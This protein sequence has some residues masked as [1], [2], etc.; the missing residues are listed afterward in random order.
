MSELGE[1]EL[2]SR[3]F[4]S[5]SH[6]ENSTPIKDPRSDG[7]L[8]DIGDDAAVLNVP[9]GQRLVVSSDTLVEGVHFPKRSPASLIAQRALRVNLSDMAAMGATPRWFTL[10]LTL[11]EVSES[12]V[13]DFSESLH[14]DARLFE[15]RLVGG[16]TTRGPLNIGIQMMGTVTDETRAITRM[17][18][19]EGD[20][21]LVTG[22]LGDAA[23][24]LD[25]LDSDDQN[26]STA[27]LLRRYWIP[28]PRVEFAQSAQKYIH[29]AC[30]ISDGLLADVGHICEASELG[31]EVDA[32]K[33]PISPALSQCFGSAATEKALTG[34]DDY[35]LCMAVSA[36]HVEQVQVLGDRYGCPVT[37]MGEFTAA[38]GIRCVNADDEILSSDALNRKGYQHF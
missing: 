14:E 17:G 25:Y 35:E 5:D 24:A 4:K 20:L 13:R 36:D 26:Q 16:D 27:D 30:D 23:G 15:C 33:L 18:A 28:E 12:W 22:T 10:A 31:V 29:A 21:L 7:V 19:R 34:G 3:Y 38:K 8:I 11:P 32:S 37:I 2:I 1:F 9:D 6:V